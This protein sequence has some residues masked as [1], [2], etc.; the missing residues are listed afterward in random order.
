MASNTRSANLSNSAKP[1]CQRY[2]TIAIHSRHD[3]A[4]NTSDATRSHTIRHARRSDNATQSGSLYTTPRAHGYSVTLVL[5]QRTGRQAGRWATR[6]GKKSLFLWEAGRHHR[7]GPPCPTRAVSKRKTPLPRKTRIS[8]YFP[9][10]H[11]LYA[12]SPLP[13]KTPLFLCQ[14]NHVTIL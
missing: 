4:N 12:V 1:D 9:E 14:Q 3:P 2:R 6:R 7:G 13:R 11:H 5:A 8:D 10:K